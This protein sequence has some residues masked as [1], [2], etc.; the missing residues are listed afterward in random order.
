M[1][2]IYHQLGDC[3]DI[4]HEEQIV[5]PVVN[6]LAHLVLDKEIPIALDITLSSEAELFNKLK[7][8]VNAH[9]YS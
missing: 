4:C 7:E 9:S 1:K 6:Y 2:T 8:I 5:E 3:F